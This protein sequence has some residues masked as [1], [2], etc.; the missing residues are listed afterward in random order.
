MPTRLTRGAD[1][2]KEDVVT[3][4]IDVT[5]SARREQ[6]TGVA[7]GRLLVAALGVF[8]GVHVG[9]QALIT[10]MRADAAK[11]RAS[12]VIITFDRDPDALLRP[13]MLQKLLSDSERLTLLRSLADELVVLTFDR[14]L[15]ALSWQEFLDSCLLQKASLASIFVGR[16]FRFGAGAAGGIKELG[17]WADAHGIEFH[18]QELSCVGGQP[19]ASS[20]VRSLV[21]AGDVEQAAVLLT[22]PFAVEGV[23]VSGQRRGSALGF[24]TANILVDADY[25]RLADCVYGGFCQVGDER[26]KAAIATGRPP[27]FV[28]EDAADITTAEGR[29][30]PGKGES[31]D[32]TAVVPHPGHFSSDG[33]KTSDAAKEAD[34]FS[35]EE[36]RPLNGPPVSPY[37]LEAHL[38]DFSGDL[39]GR[40][41]R[42]E[43]LKR[44][45]PMQRFDSVEELKAALCANVDWVARHL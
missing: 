26:Y 8:D 11:R 37:I 43:L 25:A 44:L 23:V 20:R 36:S 35:T 32:K 24:P 12:A 34:A 27:T 15:A 33:G 3:I 29:F 16:N 7:R 2:G 40:R 6:S 39:Y 30:P 45:R 9:H 18:V 19:I 10:A 1:S 21:A 5:P 42:L 31:S 38:L 17:Q 22:R 14:R 41:V 13:W 4:S 28:S